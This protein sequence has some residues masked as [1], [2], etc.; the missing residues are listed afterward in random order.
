MAK[1]PTL[2]EPILETESHNYEL[3][4]VRTNGVTLAEG[5]TTLEILN[6]LYGDMYAMLSETNPMSDF[7]LKWINFTNSEQANLD[8]IYKAYSSEYNPIENYSMTEKGKK[9][10]TGTQ[11][12]KQSGNARSEST[13]NI[14]AYNV[15]TSNPASSS[16]AT[17]NPNL[18]NVRTDNL[19]EINELSRSGNIGVTTSAQMIEE[20]IKLWIWKFFDSVFKDIDR[21][22]TI[23]VYEV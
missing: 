14:F 20:N 13:S 17:S 11:G 2:I 8:A 18:E 12:N 22:L 7:R 6:D 5:T 15:T 9:T 21:I 23:G 1:K 4:R 19:T 10:N 16:V 3:Y